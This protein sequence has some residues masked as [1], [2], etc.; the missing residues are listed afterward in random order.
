MASGLRLPFEDGLDRVS[1]VTTAQYVIGRSRH[2]C[3]IG[4]GFHDRNLDR[5]YARQEFPTSGSGRI[6][7]GETTPLT[8]KQA[9][10]TTV[11]LP[12]ARIR[13]LN[14]YFA[15]RGFQSKLDACPTPP[16]GP[17]SLSNYVSALPFLRG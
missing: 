14:T 5:L 16:N 17:F 10:A 12:D 1:S 8:D 7:R 6:S 3:F 4:F 2:V 13:T 11:G 15:Q 9:W